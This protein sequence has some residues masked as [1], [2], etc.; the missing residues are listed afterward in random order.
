MTEERFADL[1]VAESTKRALAE[2]FGYELMTKVQAK[3]I[4]PCL[5]GRDVVAKAK[6]G[7]GKTPR[8]SSPGS[9][10]FPRAAAARAR[11]AARRRRTRELAQ[12]TADEAKAL[13]RFAHAP[14][15][16]PVRIQV[17]VGG[18][19]MNREASEF[20]STPPPCSSRRPGA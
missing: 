11:R 14:G 8:S 6:T 12:Q 2:V 1:P 20:R 10:A 15:G 18:T 4:A 9:S 16:G 17:V 5:S 3:T 7:T 19:N 13:V